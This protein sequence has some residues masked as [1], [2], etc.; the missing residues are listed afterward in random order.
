[1]KEFPSVN[2]GG[3][4]RRANLIYEDV[5]QGAVDMGLVAFPEK[6]KGVD[7]AHLR[8]ALVHSQPDHPLSKHTSIEVSELKGYRV[9]GFD[10]DIPTRQS[11][12]EMLDW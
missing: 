5:L 1:M 2:V 7:I 8:R 3:E 9:I 4:Y 12:D 11:V 6:M 10:K